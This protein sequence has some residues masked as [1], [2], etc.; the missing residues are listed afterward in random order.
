MPNANLVSYEI[1]PETTYP[2]WV[3]LIPY[4]IILLLIVVAVVF[5]IVRSPDGRGSRLNSFG[6][7]RT[8]TAADGK[9]KVHVLFSADIDAFV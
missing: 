3:S 8:K 5:F 9:D 1:E 4:L 2:W 7:A 6:K